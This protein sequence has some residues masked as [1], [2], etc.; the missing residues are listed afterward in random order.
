MATMTRELLE[1]KRKPPE[2]ERFN[3]LKGKHVRVVFHDDTA[4]TAVLRWVD[5]Y[6]I[7]ILYSPRQGEREQV[8]IVY[9]STISMIGEA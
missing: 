8:W 6:T 3:E 1:K 4:L 5:Q 9:K 2:W 7:G